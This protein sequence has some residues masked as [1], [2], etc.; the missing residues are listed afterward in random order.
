VAVAL[1][2][3][4]GVGGGDGGACLSQDRGPRRLTEMSRLTERALPTGTSNGAPSSRRA[5]VLTGTTVSNNDLASLF[6]CPVCFEYVLPPITQCKSGHLVCGNCRPKLTRCPTCRVPLTSIR[7]LAM[8]KVANLVLFPCKYTSSGCGKTMPPTEKADHEE[9]C[10]FR[11]CR[12][13]CPGTSCGWQGSMDAVVPH[14]MQ[15]YNESIITLRGEVVVF[16]AVNINLAGTLEW[17]MLQSCFGFHFLL[18]LEKLEIYDGHQKFF[19][20]VQLIGTREQAENFT[21][22]LE[23]NGNR[24]RLSWEATP[25]SI[26]EG[27]ATALINSDCLIFDSEVAE[28]FAEN[29]NLSIDVTISMC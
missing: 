11:P 3:V 13:P 4:A 18:V 29:G 20:V 12:C 27:I 8:E 17:V 10:E 5:P 1:P 24:R 26:H 6:E 15:H 21:Y 25:L 19:A 16:L 9:H 22:Q 2:A 28:L 14:L 23:L 7:N